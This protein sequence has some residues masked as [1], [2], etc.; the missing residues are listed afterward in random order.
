MDTGF[1]Y[2]TFEKCIQQ[3]YAVSSSLLDG[4]QLENKDSLDQKF[5][6]KKQPL[7]LDGPDGT[8]VLVTFEYHI[9]YNISYGVPVLCFNIWKQ[10]G[11]MLTLEEYWS[12]NANMNDSNVYDTLTQM[13]HPVL[14]RP[15]LTLHP[16]KTAEI[17]QPFLTESKNLV[18]SWLSVVGHFVHLRLLEDYIKCC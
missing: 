9:V 10:D 15:F 3:M 7:Y 17:M 14:C 18:V 11:C 6:M 1:S 5:L 4:W 12:M 16:C 13:D 2:D 8:K